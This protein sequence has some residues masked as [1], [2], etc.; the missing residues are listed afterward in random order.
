MSLPPQ[1]SMLSTVSLPPSENE[2]KPSLLKNG[3]EKREEWSARS[4]AL[5]L[6]LYEE[7]Y[8]D[9]DKGNFRSKDWEQ[10]VDR[11]NMEGGGGKSVKQCRDKMDSLKKRHKLERGKKA[12]TGAE[13][14]S[15]IWFEK[16]DGM[17]GD[18][19][20]HI[21]MLLGPP[22]SVDTKFA[23]ENKFRIGDGQNLMEDDE[24]RRL[25][26]SWREAKKVLK[27]LPL[28]AEERGKARTLLLEKKEEDR[29]EYFE[30]DSEEIAHCL[31]MLVERSS[32]YPSGQKAPTILCS[33]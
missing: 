7:K 18:N 21:G 10:L 19:P 6:D 20:K 23:G 14:C 16:M 9:I 33:P 31:K 11:F 8:F 3:E 26:R 2:K 15:W 4:V 5:F 1:M 13:T 22:D 17:F 27:D 29:L 32:F 30:G 12:S 28:S 24:T 25:V